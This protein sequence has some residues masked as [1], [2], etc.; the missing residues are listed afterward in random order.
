MLLCSFTTP[1]TEVTPYLPSRICLLTCWGKG[2]Q[3]DEGK[4]SVSEDGELTRRDTSLYELAQRSEPG[5]GG[6]GVLTG[7]EG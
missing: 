2:V 7:V 4:W 6:S 3:A 5:H 1:K